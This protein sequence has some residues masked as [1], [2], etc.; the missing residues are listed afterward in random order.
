MIVTLMK[1]PPCF[2]VTVH[3][4]DVY[5]KKRVAK[6]V[7]YGTTLE[8]VRN[9]ERVR[10]LDINHGAY[11]GERQDMAF[12]RRGHRDADTCVYSWTFLDHPE[13]VDINDVIDE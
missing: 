6:V 8:I 9:M 11:V 5:A 10:L 13:P 7:G 12:L 1:M 3:I 2:K 4:V